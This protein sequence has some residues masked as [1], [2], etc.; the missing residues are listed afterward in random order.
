VRHCR[1]QSLSGETE[2]GVNT[3]SDVGEGKRKA[4]LLAKIRAVLTAHFGVDV[5][6]ITPDTHFWNDLGLDWL[7]IVELI[8]LVEEQ[9]PNLEI[10]DPGH[11]GSVA[12]I[13]RQ[14]RIVDK[15]WAARGEVDLRDGFTAPP[16]NQRV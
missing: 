7:D 13:I 6:Y 4:D 1:N 5:E 10:V 8:I 11:I 15:G 12:D 2:A 3:N 14:T 9:F 16:Q